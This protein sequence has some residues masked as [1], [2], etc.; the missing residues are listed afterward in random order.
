[1]S[2]LHSVST[3]QEI[4]FDIDLIEL[5]Y[6][7]IDSVDDLKQLLEGISSSPLET[8][9][10]EVRSEAESEVVDNID[11][12]E[13]LSEFIDK[14]DDSIINDYKQHIIDEHTNKQAVDL[15]DMAC[16]ATTEELHDLLI[17]ILN[18]HPHSLH[19]F[20][21]SKQ[22]EV[23]LAMIESAQALL[24]DLDEFF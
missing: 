11:C 7:H 10:D 12:A 15:V 6:D 19:R 23:K 14:F 18:Q 22:A 4:E 9:L 3:T 16:S 24:A 20:M 17:C 5:A 2:N 8:Y 21:V 13:S 1:M